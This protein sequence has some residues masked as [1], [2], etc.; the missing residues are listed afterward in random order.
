M[1]DQSMSAADPSHPGP[2]L[3]GQT[4]ELEPAVY[5]HLRAIAQNQMNQERRGHTLSA[6]ALVNEAYIRIAGQ[7]RL[8]NAGRAAFVHAAAEAMRRILIEHARA[9]ARVKRGG[10][11]AKLSLSDIGDVADLTMIDQSEGVIA[12]DE[13]FGRLEEHDQRIAQV[14]RLRFYGGLSVAE[15]AEILRVSERTVNNDWAYARAWMARELQRS[16]EE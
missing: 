14:V 11:A 4:P 9:R 2:D 8:R 3:P 16:A 6:T 5:A 7:H 12:F 13:A 15:T 1:Y 10:G